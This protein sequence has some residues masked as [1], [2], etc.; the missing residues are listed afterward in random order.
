MGVPRRVARRR[1][2]AILAFA[3]LAAHADTPTR[4]YSRGM[5]AR[6]ALAVALQDAPE[7]LLLDEALSAGDAGFTERCRE[8][9]DELAG[10]GRTVVVATH[11]MPFVHRTCSRALLLADG[12]VEA[13]GEPSEVTDAYTGLLARRAQGALPREKRAADGAVSLIEAWTCGE[14][15]ERRERFAHGERLELRLLFAAP[16]PIAEP[17]FRI[18]L[19]AADTGTRVTETG[20]YFLDAATGE[21]GRLRV[22]ALDGEQELRMVWPR[23]PLG[24][25]VFEWRIMVFSRTSGTVAVDV[26]LREDGIARFASDAFQEHGWTRRTLLEVD[27][28]ISLAARRQE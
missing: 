26:H 11:S 14:D 19:V 3:E 7:I 28:E 23:N 9:L 27:T 4:Y 6:L 15:G 20:T 8:R 18:E 17:R 25:G 22:P 10:S 16:R 13:D 2:E 12:R 5:R 24:S 1:L 21:L